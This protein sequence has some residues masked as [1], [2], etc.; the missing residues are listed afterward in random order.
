MHYW[1][2]I[3]VYRHEFV[4]VDMR[5][6]LFEVHDPWL[7][8]KKN[9]FTAKYVQR[10]PVNEVDATIVRIQDDQLNEMTCANL[11]TKDNKM[12]KK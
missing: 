2:G 8:Q 4:F 3:C 5:S 9:V 7:T 6:S 10:K 11:C 1:V 12:Y